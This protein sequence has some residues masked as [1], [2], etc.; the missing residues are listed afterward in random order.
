[1][2]R[3]WLQIEGCDELAE[4][5][6][7]AP[8]VYAMNPDEEFPYATPPRVPNLEVCVSP[9]PEEE[10]YI[11][12]S[13]EPLPPSPTYVPCFVSS[14]EEEEE[15][16]SKEDVPEDPIPP[17]EWYVRRPAVKRRIVIEEYVPETSVETP[18]NEHGNICDICYHDSEIVSRCR[19]GCTLAMCTDCVARNREGSGRCPQCRRLNF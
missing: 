5:F 19:H 7:I 10:E 6:L 4:I 12:S 17:V 2:T 16:E 13:P 14:D 8:N 15:E 9:V 3:T 11:P 1:M 18:W